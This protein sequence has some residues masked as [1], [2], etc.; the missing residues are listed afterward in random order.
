MKMIAGLGNPGAS[1]CRNRHNIGYMA[2]DAIADSHGIGPFRERHGGL[3]ATGRING[4]S[5]MLLKPLTFMNESGRAVGAALRYYK[6]APEDLIVIHD[7]IDLAPGK[8]RFKCGGG[9]AGHNGLR[10]VRSHVGNQF[11]RI[12]IGVGHPGG[13]DRVAGYVLGNFLD[14]DAAW[15]GLVLS[16][17][18]AALPALLEGDEARFASQVGLASAPVRR[19]A[20][21]EEARTPSAAER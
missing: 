17:I 21:I 18:A 8:V 12:R 14:E 6:M 2:V 10:S 4:G 11:H 7:E 9:I 3:A 5:V 16:S 15:R 13:S 19:K 20:R 1:H